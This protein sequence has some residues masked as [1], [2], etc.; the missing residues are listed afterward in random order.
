MSFAK[1]I[2]ALLGFL[3]LTTAAALTASEEDHSWSLSG[4]PSSELGENEVY[5]AVAND[6]AFSVAVIEVHY[7]TTVLKIGT[8]SLFLSEG[9]D[10]EPVGVR[11]DSISVMGSKPAGT[12]G[13]VRLTLF[14]PAATYPYYH[15]VAGT[16]DIIRLVFKVKFGVASGT[17]TLQLTTI[18][19]RAVLATQ[20]IEIQGMSAPGNPE[21]FNWSLS[22]ILVAGSQETEI[23]VMVRNDLWFGNVVFDVF[24]DSTLLEIKQPLADNVLLVSR[25]AAMNFTPSHEAGSNYV[26]LTVSTSEEDPAFPSIEA[27]SGTIAKLNFNIKTPMQSGETTTLQVKLSDQTELASLTMTAREFTG[28]SADVSGDGKEDVFDLLD[29][30][31]VLGGSV[32]KSV[33]SDVNDD[34]KT[35]IFDL[36]EILRQ[37]SG[38]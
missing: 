35:D 22:G 30:L 2:S 8:S 12:S 24:Y 5:I 32:P 38:K 6:T 29:L 16:G 19:S 9:T 23:F 14:S 18:N 25:A 15:V 34:G 36:L 31:K 26:R 33:F 21:D 7:D 3:F 10:F 17:T 11:M 13:V 28:P 27:G 4:T 20:E 37:L 1:I